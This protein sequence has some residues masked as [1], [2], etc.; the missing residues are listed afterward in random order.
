MTYI[1]IQKNPAFM[2]EI[3]QIPKA[4]QNT[5][6]FKPCVVYFVDTNYFLSYFL[7]RNSDQQ[8]IVNKLFK[9][10]LQ[11]K[12]CLYSSSLVFFEVYWTAKSFYQIPHQTLKTMMTQLLHL[13]F[14]TIDNKGLLLES[15]NLFTN[16]SIS[17]EDC[18][19]LVCAKSYQV[20]SIATFDKKLKSSFK[21]LSTLQTL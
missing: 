6:A 21:K 12:V 9:Q 20:N 17:L 2:T 18:Y 3:K 15:L 10:A 5:T 19:H 4:K 7:D 13:N 8:L 1:K 14:I 11:D 16:G